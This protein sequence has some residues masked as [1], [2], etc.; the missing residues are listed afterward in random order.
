[1][2]TV[3]PHVERE[4]T[5]EEIAELQAQGEDIDSGTTDEPLKKEKIFLGFHPVSGEKVY[6]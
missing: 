1:M 4:L 2:N 6:R 5:D 3:V